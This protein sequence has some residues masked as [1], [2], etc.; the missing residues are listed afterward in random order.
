MR[1][2]E[3]RTADEDDVFLIRAHRILALRLEHANDGERRIS[4]CR[5]ICPIGSTPGPN[6]F[7]EAV[8]PI[9][10]FF[11]HRLVEAVKIA[12]LD[13][14]QFR[15]VKKSGVVPVICVFQVLVSEIHRLRGIHLRR[16]GRD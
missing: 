8:W 6:R 15:I 1:V 9:T 4:V 14:A 11:A 10:A 7:S 5:M 3:C 13:T 2:L 16:H 12:P